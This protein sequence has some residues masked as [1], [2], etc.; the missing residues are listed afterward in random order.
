MFADIKSGARFRCLCF[1]GL[2]F[3]SFFFLLHL[4]VFPVGL[5]SNVFIC[6]SSHL[7]DF[8]SACLPHLL[9]CAIYR[10]GCSE[11]IAVGRPA[12]QSTTYNDNTAG[13]AVDGDTSNLLGQGSCTHTEI[14]TSP[15]W[16]VDLQGS[17]TVTTVVLYNRLFP[18][19][20]PVSEFLK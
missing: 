4:L 19:D 18:S 8:P 16:A 15:W 14:E 3:L 11:N 20:G 10:T 5:S 7:F 2:V 17:Y 1:Y 12:Y 13:L 9:T 6:L